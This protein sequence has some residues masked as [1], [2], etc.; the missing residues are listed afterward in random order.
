MDYFWI[1]SPPR[2]RNYPFAQILLGPRERK[3]RNHS[4][5]RTV[6]LSAGHTRGA[7]RDGERASCGADFRIL[8]HLIILMNHNCYLRLFPLL[9]PQWKSLCFFQ[10]K[11][12]EERV[13]Q[14]KRP[15]L[16]L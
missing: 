1:T 8:L 12:L 15:G 4:V 16:L 5:S 13:S 3:V 7:V 9:N 14:G 6:Q 2:S 10:D 11:K